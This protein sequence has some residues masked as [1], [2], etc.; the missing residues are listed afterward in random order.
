MDRTQAVGQQRTEAWTPGERQG[1][2]IEIVPSRVATMANGP[3]RERFLIEIGAPSEPTLPGL[4]ASGPRTP[5][6]LCLVIDRSG[7]MEGAPLDYAKQ[8]CAHV[9]DMLGPED[10]LS[11]VAFD[12]TVEV[13]MAPQRLTDRQRVKDGI[14]QLAPGYTTNLSDGILVARQQVTQFI[15]QRRASRMVVLSDGEPT[16]GVKEYGALVDL[17]GQTKSNG[18]TM[19]FLGFGPDYNEELLAGM[20]K[21]AG[22][23]YYYI[24]E[25]HLIPEVFRA[26]LQKLVSVS[27]TRL[28][29]TMRLSRWVNLKGLSGEATVPEGREFLLDLPDLERGAIMQQVVDLEFPNHPVG[30]YRVAGGRL[31]YSDASGGDE[32]VALDFVMEFTADAARYSS[33][34]DP[35]VE[36]AHEVSAASRA[37][38]RTVMG[39]KSNEI[40]QAVALADLQKTQAM[41]SS[42]GRLQE[43]AEVT[44]A[45][46]A[47]QGGNVGGAEKTLMGTVVNLDQGKK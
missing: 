22:G 27:A 10:V 33:P 19:T 5:L 14:A 36:Q 38:E 9:V 13:I 15:E 3:A 34:A 2:S 1:L 8:A 24:S 41:L 23:N 32:S 44:Q 47:I 29:L 18:I 7:S 20:A 17:A 21:R 6:N 43:A 37:I 16:A 31:E 12:E 35:R 39:L 46:R 42:Q 25:P 28:K 26:E 40:T 30:H 11:I 45:I 4:S